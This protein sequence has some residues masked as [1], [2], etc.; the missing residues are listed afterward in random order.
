MFK[1]PDPASFLRLKD[2]IAEEG[3]LV[4]RFQMLNDLSPAVPRVSNER[5]RAVDDQGCPI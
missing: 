2:P 4:L 3:D 5:S 1:L